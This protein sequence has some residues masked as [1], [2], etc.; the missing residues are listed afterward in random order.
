VPAVASRDSVQPESAGET[1]VAVA[2][3]ERSQPHVDASEIASLM[4]RGT[5][6]VA[7][8]NIGAARMMFK[9]AAE[10][11]DPTAAMALAQTYDPSVLE[12]LGAK[13]IT[14]DV[15]LAQQWYEK[16]RAL[17]STATPGQLSG[18]PAPGGDPATV[19]LNLLE[20]RQ[21][22]REWSER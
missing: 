6:F 5:E 10:A 20:R 2:P 11:G 8:G 21:Q 1:A 18:L 22:P 13:G 12:K 3:A 15:A 16:A 19:G 9:V 17:G 4:K 14:P 7:N